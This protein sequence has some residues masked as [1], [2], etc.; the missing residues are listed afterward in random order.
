MDPSL[1]ALKAAQGGVFTRRQAVECGYTE[2]QLK[3][4]TRPGGHWTVLRRGVYAETELVGALSD[5]DRYLLGVHAVAVS[6]WTTAV[7]SHTSAAAVHGLP[8]RP[9]W[10]ALH[11]VTRPDVLGGRTDNG[12]T[13]HRAQL[14]DVDV[15][16]SAGLRVTSPARTAV[17][18]ARLHGFTD[19]VVAA[20]AA[21]RAGA[22]RQ[23]L[24]RAVEDGRNWPFNTRARAA[25]RVADRGAQTIGETLLR[26]MV[27]E[28]RIGVPDTQYRISEGGRVAWAD[29]RVGRHLFEF[30]G[31][32]KYV[33]RSRGGVAELPVNEVVWREKQREDWMRRAMGGHG[34]SRVVWSEMFGAARERTLRRLR[35]EY[36][37][38]VARFGR[39]AA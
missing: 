12:V 17:D 31:R 13:H 34:V 7:I 11:H 16:L 26:L 15:V 18:I 35:R 23:E 19:G 5:D 25:V 24:V 27:L 30:D 9:H 37:A 36:D 39:G 21:L 32:T 38:T 29:L 1:R 10:Y 8:L 2:R 33:E 4:L 20:D 6:T 14:R 22:R 28:L 3:T